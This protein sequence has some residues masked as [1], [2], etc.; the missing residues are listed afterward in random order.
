MFTARY[1]LGVKIYFSL[2]SNFRVSKEV[3]TL[4]RAFA[5][6][7]NNGSR[8]NYVAAKPAGLESAT[9]FEVCHLSRCKLIGS[10]S[11]V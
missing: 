6:R 3:V 7:A 11:V 2:H 10:A 9:F 1:E 5:K 4:S 8:I